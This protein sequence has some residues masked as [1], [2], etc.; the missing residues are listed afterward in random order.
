M[1]NS[2]DLDKPLTAAQLKRIEYIS[3]NSGMSN[4][5][6]WVANDEAKGEL[7]KY[8]GFVE[9]E[10]GRVIASWNGK[11]YLGVPLPPH[12]GNAMKLGRAARKRAFEL[13]VDSLPPKLS[14]QQ[15]AQINDLAKEL[16]IDVTPMNFND[17]DRGRSNVIH[18]D[19]N[20]QS[21]VVCH[22]AR[23]RGLNVTAVKYDGTRT[24]ATY[25]LGER[26]QDAF[27]NPK[28]G[29]VVEPTKIKG[30]NKNATVP[31]LEKSISSPGRYVV[32][33]NSSTS[34]HV[35]IAEKLASGEIV[36]YDPQI[37]E[38]VEISSLTDAKYFEI[39]RIDRLLFNPSMIKKIITII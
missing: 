37:D 23:L 36:C 16:G 18:D 31:K 29:E 20:C 39:L 13:Y 22:E 26:F 35:F 10:D 4:Y 33:Y 15:Y 21:C 12:Y 5:R 17:A 27:I 11:D 38:F 7:M 25:Q 32:G 14:S 1:I 9:Y 28:N 3:A 24:S 30:D 34:G 19:S 6:Y 2:Y 8:I